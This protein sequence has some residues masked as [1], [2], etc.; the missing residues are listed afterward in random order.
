MPNAAMNLIEETKLYRIAGV[1]IFAEGTWNST[2]ITHD[3]LHDM[4]RAFNDLK[5]GWRPCLKLGH[6][7]Q[8]L[9]AKASGLPAIG[10]IEN[11]YVRGNKL[12]ADF[13]DIPEKVFRL[14]KTKA[15]RKVSCEV[16]FDLE[17]TGMKYKAILGAV[18]LLGAEK[19][20]VMNLTD[21]L[22]QFAKWEE[23]EVF[24]L[25][26]KQDTFKQYSQNFELTEE[27][28]P[29]PAEQLEQLTKELAEQ[30]KNFE[31]E[32]AKAAELEESA[33][34]KDLELADLKKFKS[35]AE[36]NALKLELEAK[37]AKRSAF[38]AKLESDK[39]V[40]PATKELV[41]QLIGEKQAFSLEEGKEAT[42]EDVVEKL[43]K[44]T[45]EAA[46][47]NFEESSLAEF[48]KGGDKED[49]NDKQ[50]KK[51]MEENKCSY[52]VAY[53]SVMKKK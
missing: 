12:V 42:R 38:V 49:E 21:I 1:E 32:Q 15:Y 23:A 29:M 33:K 3:D 36:A 52:D 30:K 46:K 48:A 40:T 43:L 18:A 53:K 16:Y 51:Y 19:P 5:V 2:K 9:V 8:Q 20:G 25:L 22:G 50:I 37:E 34:A 31:L 17:V 45:V 10:W 6:D 44:L 47:V 39:L 4:V 28:D 35:E 41:G 14:I 7:D 13:S 24:A 27:D 11:L 26:E